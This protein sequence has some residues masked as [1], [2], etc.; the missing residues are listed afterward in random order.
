MHKPLELVENQQK[1]NPY[2]SIDYKQ[3]NT[4]PCLVIIIDSQV[5]ILFVRGVVF[6]TIFVFY[7]SVILQHIIHILSVL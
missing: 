5:D 3:I 7:R 2:F 6:E 1:K 4:L